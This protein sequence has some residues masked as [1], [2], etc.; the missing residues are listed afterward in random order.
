MMQPKLDGWKVEC[1]GDDIAWMK[2]GNDGRLYAVNPEAGFFG[3]ATGTSEK[4]NPHAMEMIKRRTVFTNVAITQDGDV[5]WEGMTKSPP[6]NLTSWRGVP[7]DPSQGPAAHPNSRFTVSSDQCPVIDPAAKNPD[8]VPIS[9]II[10]GGRRSDVIPLVS[11]AIDWE[12]GVFY[13]ATMSSETTAAATGAVGKLRHDPFAMHAFCGY[14]MGDYFSHWMSMGSEEKAIAK[15]RFFY[16]NWFQKDEQGNF[17]W[18]GFG[19]NIRVLKWIFERC[20]SKVDAVP[21]PIG[22]VP[23]ISSLDTTGLDLSLQQKE[24]L[25]DVDKKK[26]QHEVRNI[27]DY[28]S[29]FSDKLPF[30]L[31][32]QLED[33]KK[34][35]TDACSDPKSST[36]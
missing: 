24:A 13:G 4:S 28:F 7:W 10:F 17:L 36:S 14:N 20:D 6:E 1:I 23:E 29:Q 19:D 25:L 34:R 8:G 26:W 30:E 35:L 31:H 18:P 32:C 5:W 2:W 11:E 9:A 3:V 16:V 21:T 15:P 22:Y 12:H 27:E 33:L